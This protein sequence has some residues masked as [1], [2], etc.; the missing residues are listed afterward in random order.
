VIVFVWVKLHPSCEAI[1][2][3][4]KILA[5][6]T[7]NC[8]RSGHIFLAIFAFAVGTC[9][10]THV[11]YTLEKIIKLETAALPQRSVRFEMGGMMCGIRGTAA[12]SNTVHHCQRLN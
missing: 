3:K 4:N 11:K 1:G 7:L 5:F 10:A 6:S 2:T 8:K 9:G 12:V